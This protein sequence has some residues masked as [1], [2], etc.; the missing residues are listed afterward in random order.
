M[1]LSFTFGGIPA[2]KQNRIKN[3]LYQIVGKETPD[4]VTEN[5]VKEHIKLILKK[6]IREVEKAQAISQSEQEFNNSF[7]EPI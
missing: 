6:R 5:D 1:G 4:D 7:E 2:A 3:G